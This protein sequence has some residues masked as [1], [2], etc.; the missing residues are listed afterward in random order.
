VTCCKEKHRGA[1][2]V[3]PRCKCD[4]TSVPWFDSHARELLSPLSGEVA[5]VEREVAIALRGWFVAG[6]FVGTAFGVCCATLVR[7]M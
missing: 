4:G 7:F 1:H 3:C 5:P 2:P 6:I